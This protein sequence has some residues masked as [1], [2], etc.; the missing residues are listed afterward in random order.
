MQD[1]NAE[2]IAHFLLSEFRAAEWEQ[3]GSGGEGALH[4]NARISLSRSTLALQG[5][6]EGIQS[7]LWPTVRNTRFFADR[8]P[9]QKVDFHHVLVP[10]DGALVSE[11]ATRTENDDIAEQSIDL[12]QQE[13]YLRSISAFKTVTD[14]TVEDFDGLRTMLVKSLLQSVMMRIDA[15][16]IAG[17]GSEPNV[18]GVRN[19]TGISSQSKSIDTT[20]VAAAKAAERV[21]SAGYSP[22]LLL[23]HPADWLAAVTTAAVDPFAV[24]QKLFGIDVFI[25]EA[26]PSGLPTVMDTS[27]VYFL[28][29]SPINLMM[30][31]TNEDNYIMNMC[32]FRAEQRVAVAVTDVGAVCKVVA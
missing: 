2:M 14:E 10:N 7:G 27:G 4:R 28:E 15:Q 12:E 19:W 17:D 16:I 18:L 30:S 29:R 11:A 32:T 22:N 26:S 9:R 31:K 5:G 6:S 23:I 13:I 25:S 20:L 24:G 1:V 8:L 3:R 21:Y